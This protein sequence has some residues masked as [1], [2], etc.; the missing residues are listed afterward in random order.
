MPEMLDKGKSMLE[1]VA[2]GYA[3]D[4]GLT[5]A[6]E[7]ENLGYEWLL[8]LVDEQHTVRVG[9]S[10]DEIA[11]FAEVEGDD[12]ETKL[13]IRNALASLSM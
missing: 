11:F 9:F 13:K 2:L 10:P 4:H 12:R 5:P 7:W 8:R 3:K 6:V 1:R